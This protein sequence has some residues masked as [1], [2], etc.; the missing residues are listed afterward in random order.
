MSIL[1]IISHI[2]RALPK[3]QALAW[4]FSRW[5]W[6]GMII[7]ILVTFPVVKIISKL[8][9]AKKEIPFSK[10]FT[11]I[12]RIALQQRKFTFLVFI[13]NFISQW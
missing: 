13:C 1:G 8:H 4:A 12:V 5:I 11:L 3:W 10:S 2:P 6:L 7:S 9:P